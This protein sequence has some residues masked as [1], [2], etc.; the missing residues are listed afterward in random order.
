MSH[1]PD[2]ARAVG[3]VIDKLAVG[4][5]LATD[6]G[7]P[8]GNL[9]RRL[10]RRVDEPN[11]AAAAGLVDRPDLRDIVRGTHKLERI[12]CAGVTTPVLRLSMPETPAILRLVT[13]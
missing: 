12:Q 6:R 11:P 9:A 8:A 7:Q 4:R 10:P 3:V 2:V 1:G 13:L 5:G